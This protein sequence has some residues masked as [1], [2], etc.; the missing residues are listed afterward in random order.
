MPRQVD[1][2]HRPN[3]LHVVSG[4]ALKCD[5][6]P[7]GRIDDQCAIHSH[8]HMQ[9]GIHVAMIKI[10]ARFVG[11]PLIRV[12]SLD[13]EGI[14]PDTVVECAGLNTVMVYGVGAHHHLQYGMHDIALIH[15]N[16][17][18]RKHCR[19]H[20]TAHTAIG[21]LKSERGHIVSIDYLIAVHKGDAIKRFIRCHQAR[22]CRGGWV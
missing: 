12:L 19:S 8:F 14:M 22:S 15:A 7:R 17:R 6:G 5:T 10:G 9:H 1:V 13:V 3:R 11:L 18:R 21:I 16:Q 2:I 4:S 20:A